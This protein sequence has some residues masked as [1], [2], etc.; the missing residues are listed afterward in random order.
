MIGDFRSAGAAVG[1]VGYSPIR[2]KDVSPAE[3]ERTPGLPAEVFTRSEG[4]TLGSKVG[5]TGAM[6]ARVADLQSQNSAAVE[7]L[8][9]TVVPMAVYGLRPLSPALREALEKVKEDGPSPG[10][11]EFQSIDNEPAPIWAQEPS[12]AP[13]VL[14]PLFVSDAPLDRAPL[15]GMFHAS[16]ASIYT[17]DKVFS[18]LPKELA[19]DLTS[20]GQNQS[21]PFAAILVDPQTGAIT[22]LEK[23]KGDAAPSQS[24]PSGGGSLGPQVGG[25]ETGSTF[26]RTSPLESKWGEIQTLVSSL[27][28]ALPDQP[29]AAELNKFIA[30]YADKT[31]GANP[32]DLTKRLNSLMHGDQPPFP[33]GPSLERYSRATPLIRQRLSQSSDES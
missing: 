2:R 11:L 23:S 32:L 25:G 5:S 27:G 4:E 1:A 12:N 17:P 26:V 29:N 18:L 30:E 8:A 28:G 10:S 14:Q 21:D 9:G 16:S 24:L 6:P 22:P 7:H 19:D 20:L 15:D 31:P 3:A 13:I 33:S